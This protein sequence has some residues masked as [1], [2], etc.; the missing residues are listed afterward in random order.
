MTVPQLDDEARRA[1]LAKA[2]QARQD[3]AVLKG[4][5]KAGEVTLDQVLEAADR[6]DVVA[7][8]RTV[9]VIESMPGIG[10]ITAE[11]LMEE[12]AIA[13]TRSIAPEPRTLRSRDT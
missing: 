3:R 12:L 10:R 2:K 7:K 4:A 13:P 1:A 5:L 6:N 9:E 8:M 11:A